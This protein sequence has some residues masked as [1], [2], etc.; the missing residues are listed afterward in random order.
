VRGLAAL[1][2]LAGGVASAQDAPVDFEREVLPILESSCFSC[3]SGKA[4]KL[5]ANLRLDGKGW[6]LKGGNYGG[7]VAAG[8]AEGS[9]LF[10]LISLP[11]GD[12]D[13]MPPKKGPLS[14]AQIETFRRWIEGGATFGDW[15]GAP[16]GASETMDGETMDGEA[17]GGG[18]SSG[19]KPQ[20][21]RIRKP[22]APPPRV[23]MLK[24]LAE[25]VTPADPQHLE[26]ARKAGAQVEPIL[27]GS[28]LLRVQFVSNEADVTDATLAALAPLAGRITHL[29]LAKTQVTDAG[30]QAVGAMPKLSSLNLRRTRV[31]DAGLAHLAA[32]AELRTLNLYGTAVTDGGVATLAAL[33]RLQAVYLWETQVTDA[34]ASR[35]RAERPK[36]RVQRALALPAVEEP[37][38]D[39]SRDR[40]R[41]K[42]RK[43]PN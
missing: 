5:K 22:S 8:D 30:L 19:A 9:A 21:R 34:G 6:I 38:G 26:A 4:K 39:D 14:K 37:S 7:V 33:P 17:M 28:P 3:H 18:S 42:R 10:E 24:A 27:P 11:A 15:T 41:K 31:G 35:L 25:G 2:L 32:L 13:L 20:A 16:G 43:K 1:V 29:T 12:P 23:V 36:L 40:R